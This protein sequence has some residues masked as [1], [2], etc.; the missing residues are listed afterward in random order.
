MRR[1]DSHYIMRFRAVA[2]SK[3]DQSETCKSDWRTGPLIRLLR[4]KLL[5]NLVVQDDIEEC[6]VHT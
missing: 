2:V 6:A 5:G 3:R 4:G 1:R